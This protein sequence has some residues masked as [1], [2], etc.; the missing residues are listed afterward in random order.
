MT[1][2]LEVG[3]QIAERV[4]SGILRPGA[5]LPAVRAYARQW[6]TSAATIVRAYRYLAEGGVIVL[7]ARRRARVAPDGMI[8]ASH[9]LHAD[10]VFRLA[11]SDDPALQIVLERAGPTVVS[12]GARGSFQALRALAR[13]DADGAAIHLRHRCGTHNAPF[14]Q[15]LLRDRHPHLLHLWRREQGLFVAHGNPCG[16]TTPADL[17]GLRVAKREVGTGTR[18]LLDQLLAT[19]GIAADEVAGPELG[20]HVEVAL[21]VAAGITD[22][23][24]GV[25]A[26][27]I[28]L[29]L[30]FI[31]LIWETYDI[32]LP[33]DA[34]GAAKPLITTLRDP[35]VQASIRLLGGYDLAD[36]GSVEA[37]SSV[38]RQS[39]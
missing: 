29:D 23:G 1:R 26:V 17:A 5:E 14:A 37:L 35:T 8:A 7:A 3:T 20:S 25:R 22:T 10:R 21:A 13:S 38:P 24:L 32:A 31:P 34:L 12:V 16:I 2:Y 36:S 30:Q 9:L 6:G 33:G 11:G 15:A 39:S 4:R 18:I 27:A 28:D 19:A